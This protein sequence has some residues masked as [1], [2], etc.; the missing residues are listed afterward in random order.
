M[1]CIAPSGLSTLAQCLESHIRVPE[2]MQNP[3]TNN[4]IK[5]HLQL[6][7]PFNGQLSNLKIFQIVFLLELFGTAYACRAEIDT[8]N[9]GSRPTQSV[10]CRLGCSATRQR[11]WIIFPVRSGRPKQMIIGAA[12]FRSCQTRLYLSRLSSGGG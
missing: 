12:P 4:L 10:L 6:V 9:L 5:A 3:R 8:G 2:M 7:D 1:S 11:G